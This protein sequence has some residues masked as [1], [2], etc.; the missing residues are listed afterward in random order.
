MRVPTL[1]RTTV[2]SGALI[3][4]SL[5]LPTV[6]ASAAPVPGTPGTLACTTVH[7]N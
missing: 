4:S 3:A 2:L 5:T 1:L 7:H 6:S